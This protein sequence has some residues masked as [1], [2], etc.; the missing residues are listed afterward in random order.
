MTGRPIKI[1]ILLDG[2]PSTP[3][4]AAPPRTLLNRLAPAPPATE[5]IHAQAAASTL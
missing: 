4:Q 3:A 2:T 1:E 5:Q